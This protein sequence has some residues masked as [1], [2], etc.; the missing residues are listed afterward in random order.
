MTTPPPHSRMLMANGVVYYVTPDGTYYRHAPYGFVVC[1]P[2][3]R[4]L[5]RPRP[6]FAQPPA[7]EFTAPTPSPAPASQTVWIQNANGSR[8]PVNLRAAEGGM[9]IGPR[10]EYYATLP[11]P[12]QLAPV[13]GL[14][15]ETSTN[16]TVQAE[17]PRVTT[18]VWINNDNGSRTPVTLEPADGG[19]WQGPRGEMYDTLPTEEQLRPAYGLTPSP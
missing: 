10:G 18:T 15:A 1:A 13:Y 12:E 19:L 7:G 8:S 11:A 14:E 6:P 16:A 3:T 2:P 5:H 4:S 17:A 9:W